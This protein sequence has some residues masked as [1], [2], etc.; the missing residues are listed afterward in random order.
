MSDWDRVQKEIK[1]YKIKRFRWK[2]ILGVSLTERILRLRNTGISS[3][4][5]I[6]SIMEDKGVQKYIECNPL[7]A[8]KMLDCIKISVCARYGENKTADKLAGDKV[9]VFDN[10]IANKELWKKVFELNDR[11][12]ILE[13]KQ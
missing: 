4:L 12:K 5:T 2:T 13:D 3:K 8:E 10:T 6:Q 1:R 9:A 11:I 7:D